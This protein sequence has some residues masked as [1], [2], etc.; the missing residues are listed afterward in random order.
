MKQAITILVLFG[1]LC[2]A[3][4]QTLHHDKLD[5][6]VADEH[7]DLGLL[8][9]EDLADPSADKIL[10]WDNGTSTTIWRSPG[11]G[12]GDLLADGTVPM[13][14]NWDIGNYDLTLKSLTGDG[15]IEGAT[16]T[17]GGNEVYSS[18]E[19]PSGELG[20]TYASITVDATHSGSAH[21]AYEPALTDEAS[22]Y[23]TLSDVT[24]FWESGDS[25]TGAVGTDEAYASGW[26][27]DTG[28]AEKDDIYDYLHQI[29]ADD[30]GSLVDENWY[31]TQSNTINFS[32]AT[33]TMLNRT[34]KIAILSI[35]I[36]FFI[37]QTPQV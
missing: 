24:Q 13:T 9:L 37:A 2:V 10:G 11:T 6:F 23:S 28:V 21:S 31:T 18:A 14:S 26:N 1:V 35:L 22:L 17:E 34:N 12:T 33:L 3:G 29:D 16:L 27:A 8:G 4:T 36:V 30:D 19:T 15:T 32:G 7:L 5:G 25:V 20:G